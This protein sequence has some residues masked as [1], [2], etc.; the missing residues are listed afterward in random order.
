MEAN[1]KN[2]KWN[3][4]KC[5]NRRPFVCTRE[6]RKNLINIKKSSKIYDQ[7]V[8]IVNLGARWEKET[9]FSQIKVF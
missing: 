2:G 1:E 4:I 9:L 3:D 7:N 8:K 5:N 6:K